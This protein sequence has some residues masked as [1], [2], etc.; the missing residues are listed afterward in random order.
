MGNQCGGGGMVSSV[1]MESDFEEYFPDVQMRG[2]E[3]VALVAKA[4]AWK[5]TRGKVVFCEAHL[6]IGLLRKLSIHV[7]PM[8]N[9]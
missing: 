2:E 4:K 1:E 7:V 9:V 3:R 8:G 6:K 5:K